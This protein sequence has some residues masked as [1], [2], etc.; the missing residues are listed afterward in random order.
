LQH[1]GIGGGFAA[2]IKSAELQFFAFFHHMG[3]SLSFA[4]RE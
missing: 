4:P 3:W 1:A 2:T